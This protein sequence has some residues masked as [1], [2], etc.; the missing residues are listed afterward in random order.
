MKKP[1]GVV[2]FEDVDELLLLFALLTNT[3]CTIESFNAAAD[4]CCVTANWLYNVAGN[5][6]RF[7]CIFPVSFV[8]AF[9]DEGVALDDDSKAIVFV[10]LLF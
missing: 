1:V 3:A 4:C 8:V 7:L 2:S 6:F 10:I 5:I 9:N